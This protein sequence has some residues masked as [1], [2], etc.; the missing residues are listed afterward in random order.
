M[1]FGDMTFEEIQLHNQLEDASAKA[2]ATG[3]VHYVI[4]NADHFETWEEN[5][6]FEDIEVRVYP[7][8]RMEVFGERAKR[9]HAGYM[10]RK[11]SLTSKDKENG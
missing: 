4:W 7:G 11:P 8:G 2:R 9:I 1:E 5:P 3:E 10:S 6:G